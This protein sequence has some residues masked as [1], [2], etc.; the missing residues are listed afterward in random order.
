MSS[1]GDPSASSGSRERVLRG[2]GTPL[3]ALLTAF[4]LGALVIW[5]TS[6]KLATIL[7]AYGGLADGALFKQRGLSESL[8]ATTPYILTS[9]AVALGF[10]AGLFNIGAEGQFY[11]GALTAVWVGYHFGGLPAILHL[12]LALAAGALGGAAWAAVPAYLKAKAG[13]H[14][15]ITTMMANY[16]AF[17]LAEFLVSGPMKDK[18]ATVPKT[19]DVA[20]NAQLW[21][22]WEVPQRLQEPLNALAAALVLGLLAFFLVRWVQGWPARRSKYK[23]NAERRPLMY[24]TAIAVAAVAFFVLPALTRTWWPFVDN[25]DRLHVGLLLAIAAAVFTWWLLYRTTIGFE[26][27]T[28]GANPDAARY[29]G[30]NVGRNIVLAMALSGALAGLAGGVEILGLEHNLPISFSSGYGFDS[31]AIALVA[32]ND[33]FGILAA[34]FLF[35]AMRN[36]ADLMELRSGVSKYVISLLQAMVLLFVAAPTM[37]GW[38]YRLK[39][40]RRADE[41]PLTRG[42]GG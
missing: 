14:E 18:A 20:A 40:E 2:I 27:R 22:L 38:L 24:G 26:M 10:K 16:I 33:P 36:G 37:V 5:I 19:P 32:Q 9:L 1:I 6:G 21:R 7:P 39:M 31:I 15:V 8:I 35:G 34:A 41:A 11:I 28:I 25:K 29:A 12:P 4:V 30:I 23:S 3:L 42:W 17:R 13:A